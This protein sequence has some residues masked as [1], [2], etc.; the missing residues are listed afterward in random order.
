MGDEKKLLYSLDIIFLQMQHIYS[1]SFSYLNLARNVLISLADIN[2][3]IS[4][5][6]TDITYMQGDVDIVYN[7]LEAYI[8]HAF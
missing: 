4:M 2:A 6:N 1:E 7:Y 8:N 3:R 5:L